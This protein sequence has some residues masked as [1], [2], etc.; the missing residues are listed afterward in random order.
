MVFKKRW[1]RL[2]ILWFFIDFSSK[3]DEL[4]KRNPLFLK[5]IDFF[6]FF[7]SAKHSEVGIWDHAQELHSSMTVPCLFLLLGTACRQRG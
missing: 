5:T 2:G 3:S 4:P 1:F 7:Y 6:F